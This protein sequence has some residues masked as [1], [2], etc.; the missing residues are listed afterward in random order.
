[1]ES[2]NQGSSRREANNSHPD[3]WASHISNCASSHLETI[4]RLLSLIHQTYTSK[5][6]FLSISLFAF[7]LFFLPYS[8]SAQNLTFKSYCENNNEL[9]SKLDSNYIHYFLKELKVKSLTEVRISYDSAG[10]ILDSSIVNFYRFD[11]ISHIIEHRFDYR[12]STGQYKSE[13]YSYSPNGKVT[14]TLTN[15][16]GPE[17]ILDGIYISDKLPMY[18]ESR[19]SSYQI[20]TIN[21]QINYAGIPYNLQFKYSEDLFVK[22]LNYPE[23]LLS[24]LTFSKGEKLVYKHVVSYER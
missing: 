5:N 22:H 12:K 18:C 8:L 4:V 13:V 19:N 23:Y 15:P 2:I 11:N 7:L 21:V 9:F 6:R 24:G 17:F 10:K 1:M 3:K 20:E 16:F 14:T